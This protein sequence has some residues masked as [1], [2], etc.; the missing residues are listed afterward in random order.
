MPRGLLLRLA[1]ACAAAT[2]TTALSL[3]TAG[4]NA[5][6]APKEY[7]VHEEVPVLSTK[8]GPYANPS[9]AYPYYSLPFCAP[10]VQEREAHALGEVLAGD[11]KVKTLYDLNFQA[12]VSWR[13]LCRKVLSEDD[14]KKFQTAV[15]EEYFFELLV[16]GLPVWGYV[17]DS[18]KETDL[19]LSSGNLAAAADPHKYV[20]AHFHFSIG[21][22]NKRIVEVNL[23]ADPL[24]RID[25]TGSDHIHFGEK[26]ALGESD[27]ALLES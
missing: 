8:V 14:L 26:H 23:T 4:A 13:R 19:I 17:G 9:E 27:S 21:Y 10:Q 25:V 24:Y 11:N 16:D 20:H 3:T 22:N 6:D 12:D 5:Q 1:A 2:A 18:D 7:A 15:D